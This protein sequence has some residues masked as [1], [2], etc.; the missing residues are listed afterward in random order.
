MHNKVYRSLWFAQIGS[1]VGTWMQTVGAQWLLVERAH[2]ATLVALVQTASLLP[3]MA[4]SLPAGV[5]ADVLDRRRLLLASQFSMALVAGALAVL[6]GFGLT[7]PATLLALTFLLGCGQAITGP[8]W[9]AI[10][11]ELVDREQIPAAAA[12]G[13]LT[14]NLAR[15]V[16]PAIAGL[17]IAETGP[18][19]VFAINAVSFVGVLAALAAWRRPVDDS[20][21]AESAVSALQAGT[22]YVRNAP[23]VTRILLRAALFVVPAS[24]LWALLP[25]VARDHLGLGAGGYGGLLA[26]LGVGAVLGAL[27]MSRL[28]RRLSSN[29]MLAWSAVAFGLGTLVLALPLGSAAVPVVSVFMV[30]C[31]LAWTASLSSLNA[32]LQLTLP[33]WVR[34]RG[35]GAYL[36]VFM[37]GHAIGALG[38]GLLAGAVGQQWTL[39]V[40]ALLLGLAALSVLRWPLHDAVEGV[41]QVGEAHWPEPVL[42]FE[43]DPQDGPVLVVKRYRV[44]PE[45]QEAFL[46]AMQAVGASRRRTGATRW[47]VYREGAQAD[48]FAEVFAIRSWDEH[49]R[50]HSDRL[51]GADRVFEERALALTLGETPVEHLL[52]P[53]QDHAGTA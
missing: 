15:A 48:G 22:R 37:G 17:I 29:G 14:V 2:A 3:V 6:T 13:S 45:N 32:G 35:L 42:M 44:A 24:A 20:S 31:G 49:L 21:R 5:L 34:A 8:A 43:P 26:A 52:P 38:W 18:A 19:A 30:L 36:L 10:Q 1:N 41:G 51:T 47:E 27:C 53:S 12:L 50:Q 39:T 46:A 33:P 28:R 25:V 40:A 4:L 23:A 16:G 7:T 11:P 9:Q